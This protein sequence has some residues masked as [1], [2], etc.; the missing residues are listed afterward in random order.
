MSGRPADLSAAPVPGAHGGDG[1][2]LA[3]ALGVDPSAVLDLSASMNPCAPDV[4]ALAA[5]RLDALRRYPDAT[6]ATIATAAAL[7]VDPDRVVLTNGG[8]EAIALVA[9]DAFEGDVR[10]PEF[11]LY[12]RHLAVVDAGSGR[13]RSNP[14]NPTGELAAPD[15]E[16]AVWDEA[17]WPLAT[18]S[19][20][21]GDADRGA[22][23]VGSLTK[24]FACPGLRVGYVLAPDAA[25]ADRL[26]RRQPQWSVNGL[27]CDLVPELLDLADLQGWAQAT[28]SLQRE[29]AGVLRSA[30]Y[31][32][33]AP[34]APWVLVSPAGDLRDRLARSAIMVRDCGSFGLADT[35]RMGVPGPGGL[36]R[37]SAA[38]R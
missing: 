25:T 21:R 13:W 30:G 4:A 11:S 31:R 7:G 17:F 28:R 1:A 23:V 19:W 33:E 20:T 6:A 9:Q 26:R 37:V 3:A 5:R 2:R 32:A 12:R 18:G 36:E 38:V 34:A 29:L 22:T 8:S 24:L 10:D 15:D 35:V 16:A 27:A 14:N